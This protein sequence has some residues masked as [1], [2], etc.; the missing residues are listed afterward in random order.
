MRVAS[1]YMLSRERFLGGLRKCDPEKLAVAARV[2]QE[3]TLPLKTIAVR[4]H[5]GT[6]RN[7]KTRLQEWRRN[8]TPA[9]QCHTDNLG[10][11]TKHQ[12]RT[13]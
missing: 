9:P 13:Q 2:R 6:P 7:A 1:N 5:L 8:Q 3:T 4:L 12:D 11:L 10:L